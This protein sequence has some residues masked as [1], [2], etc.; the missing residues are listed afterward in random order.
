[1][2]VTLIKRDGLIIWGYRQVVQ[3]KEGGRW[4]GTGPIGMGGWDGHNVTTNKNKKRTNKSTQHST[5]LQSKKVMKTSKQ[6]RREM[7]FGRGGWDK[8][9]A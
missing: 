1:M 5:K 3:G 2:L 6:A 7:K 8:S 9:E 4:S